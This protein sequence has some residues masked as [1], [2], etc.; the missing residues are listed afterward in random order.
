M[1]A[2]LRMAVPLSCIEWLPAVTPSSGVRAVSAVT[3]SMLA[4]GTASSS[5]ATWI[6]AV[7]S[8]WPSS[9]LPVNTVIMSVGVDADP[10]I[11]QG[12]L[13]E[14]AGQGGSRLHDL[15]HRPVRQGEGH[16]QRTLAEQPASREGAHSA[17]SA[18][19]AHAAA[20]GGGRA[21]HRAQDAHVG[22][23]AAEIGRHVA[24]A[25]RPRSAGCCVPAAPARA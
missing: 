14:V 18:L 13:V 16:D 1:A 20:H 5:A 6:S 8:P 24:R 17:S 2:A 11:E 12:E 15:A 10:R 23:A 19:V 22:A 25:A 4:G 3:S 9:A 21:P 7:F